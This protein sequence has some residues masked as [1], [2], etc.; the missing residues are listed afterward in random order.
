MQRPSKLT[1]ALGIIGLTGLMWGYALA[2]RDRFVLTVNGTPQLIL[3][4]NHP[5]VF[6]IAALG[7]FLGGFLLIAG[8]LYMHFGL[9]LTRSPSRGPW[10]FS[11]FSIIPFCIALLLI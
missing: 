11:W 1:V 3:R 6:L 4:S 8:V 7:C 10:G 2:S 9:R 5:Q